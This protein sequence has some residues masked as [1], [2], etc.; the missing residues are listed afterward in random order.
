[1]S[2]KRLRIF[3]GPNGSGKTTILKKLTQEIPFGVY[4]NADDIEKSLRQ[5]NSLIFDFYQIIV[6]E[7]EIK[8]FFKQSQFSPKKTNNSTLYKKLTIKENTLFVSGEINSYLAADLADFIRKKLLSN[9]LSFTF[10]TV[11]S[12]ESKLQFIKSAKELGYKIYL[13][14]SATEDPKININRVGIR[15]SQNGHNVEDIKIEERYYRCLSLLKNAILLTDRAYIWDNSS[16]VAVLFAEITNG[17]DI[18]IIDEENVPN[19]F[20]DYVIQKK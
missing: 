3:A 7:D 8:T 18:K 6:D 16:I 11:M 20:Y 13:Y 17:N 15:V 1:M 19:W 9:G 5:T 10:E 14:F 4:V 2:V 12:H